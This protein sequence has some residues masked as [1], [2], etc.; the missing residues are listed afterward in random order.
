[1]QTWIIFALLSAFFAALVAILSKIGVSGI[2]T[3]FATTVRS[4][5]M[6]VF[7][8]ATSFLFG[9]FSHLSTLTNKALLF[10]IFAGIAGALSW[11]FYFFALKNGPAPAV[12]AIDRL[13]VVFVLILAVLF[14][15]DH[16]TFKSAIGVMLIFLGAILMVLK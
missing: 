6:A 3:T 13:S 10:I 9:K 5:V 16:F 4:I 1:M 12:A 14:L 15:G 2:D 7:L 8:I 11:L